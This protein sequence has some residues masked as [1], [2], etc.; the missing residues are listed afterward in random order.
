MLAD[1]R[2]MIDAAIAG[3]GIAQLFDRVAEPHLASAVLQRVC[4]EVDADG[5]PVHALIPLGRKMPPKTRVVL[6]HLAEV[7]RRPVA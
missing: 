1:G 6:D 5:P 4:P 2:A 3:L 7:L